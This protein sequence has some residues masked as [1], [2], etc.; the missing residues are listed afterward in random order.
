M[1]PRGSGKHLHG[2]REHPRVGCEGHARGE[3]HLLAV[4]VKGTVVRTPSC[5]Q[6]KGNVDLLVGFPAY[7]R[8][9]GVGGREGERW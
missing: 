3:H 9:M 7:E 1:Q 4:T 2:D 5:R 6:G 8:E